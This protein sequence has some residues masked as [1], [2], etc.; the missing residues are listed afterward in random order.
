[1]NGLAGWGFP[2][3]GA[4]FAALA[5][6]FGRPQYESCS[7]ETNVLTAPPRGAGRDARRS[8]Y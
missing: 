3:A 2:E 4:L 5:S 1:M 8:T 6:G 7:G